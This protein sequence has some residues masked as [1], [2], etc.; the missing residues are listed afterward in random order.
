MTE[1]NCCPGHLG[2]GQW[3]HQL[4]KETDHMIDFNNVKLSYTGKRGCMCGCLGTYRVASSHGVEAANKDAG[5]DAYSETNDRAVKLAV[6][7]LNKSIDW[8]DPVC[9]ERHVNDNHAWFD[10]ATRTCVVYF[11]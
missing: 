5:W 1:I 3:P 8:N 9:V 11:K 4:S 6:N 2:Q 10:T 7:K